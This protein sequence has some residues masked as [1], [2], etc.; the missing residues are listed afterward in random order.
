M[1][2]TGT[3]NLRF[4]PRTIEHLGVKM[5]STL[6]PALAELI[7]NSYD[8][9]ASEVKLIFHEKNGKPDSIEIID[10]GEGMTGDDIQNRFLI[11]G[12]NRR[13]EDG[14]ERTK[15]FNRLP[16]GKKGLGKLALFGLAKT[17][18][19]KTRKE[20]K[21]CEFELD[22]GRLLS[23]SGTYDEPGK[24]EARGE[25]PAVAPADVAG[26]SLRRHAKAA[27]GRKAIVEETVRSNGFRTQ[28]V[29]QRKE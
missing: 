26:R 5:Y 15:R 27:P 20:G 13:K 11:I 1:A 10:N 23:S 18:I 21:E 7:S 25:E 12:R 19:I 17:I 2:Q 14:D 29:P 9:D 4:D 6:P 3:F 24:R 22:W 8:A 28:G 16:I